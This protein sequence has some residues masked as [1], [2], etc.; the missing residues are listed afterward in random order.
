MALSIRALFRISKT[1]KNP[2][3]QKN[4]SRHR[5]RDQSNRVGKDCEFAAFA[6]LVWHGHPRLVGFGFT[7]HQ[8]PRLP[9]P[10]TPPPPVIP[11]WRRFQGYHPRPSQIGVDL[12]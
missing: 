9:D 1:F 3:W 6:I 7:D 11:D 8:M 2:N 12:T 5:R 10:T 4:F